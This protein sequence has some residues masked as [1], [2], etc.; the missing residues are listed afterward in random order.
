MAQL[1]GGKPVKVYGSIMG[2]VIEQVTRNINRQT[3]SWGR[4]KAKQYA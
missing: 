1:K 2:C 4:Y 3:T